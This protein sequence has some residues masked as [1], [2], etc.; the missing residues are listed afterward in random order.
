MLPLIGWGQPQ[1]LGFQ[2][3]GG[4]IELGGLRV[5]PTNVFSRLTGYGFDLN[6]DNRKSAPFFYSVAVPEGNYRVEILLGD[7]KSATTN[8]I[9][10]ESRRLM[11]ESAVTQPGENRWVKFTVNVRT[12]RIADGSAV[13]LKPREQG[14]LH[15]D[16]KLTLEFKGARPGLRF[17]KITPIDHVITVFLAGDSTVT[18]QPDEPWNSW[19]QMLPRF[20]TSDVA[21][22]NHAESGESLKNSL[23]ARRIAKILSTIRS[24]DYLFVQFG[25]NDMKD[26]ATNAVAVFRANLRKLVADT[27][28]LGATPVLVTSMER[29]AGVTQ[30][31]LTDYPRTMREVAQ[32]DGVALIDLHT[33][34]KK[35]YAALGA[36]LDKAF[37]DGTHHNAYGSY[38]MARCVVQGIRDAKL[39][40]AKFIAADVGEFDPT[41]PDPVGQFDIPASPNQS[42]VKPD[43]N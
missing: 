35:L 41:K 12:P 15:W 34:S 23:A 18:D 13:K 40:L 9:K 30:D 17:L 5:T 32:A 7:S 38:E 11:I 22:A 3:G 37:Q 10:A 19:G 16:D 21:V 31:T 24:G 6:T 26:R 33:M 2:F 43:G 4:E 20:F 36:D 28:A 29:K 25:H 27:R 14:V 42:L 8:T 1:P 39:P